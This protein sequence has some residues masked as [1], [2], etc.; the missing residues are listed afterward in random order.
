MIF[1]WFVES[2]TH[3]RWILYSHLDIFPSFSF[4]KQ[5]CYV[6]VHVFMMCSFIYWTF[7]R[8]MITLRSSYSS[9]VLY[10]KS[11][12][13]TISS[14]I[15]KVY[16]KFWKLSPWDIQNDLMFFSMIILVWLFYYDYFIMFWTFYNVSDTLT[17]WWTLNNHLVTFWLFL[18]RNIL[19]HFNSL[20]FLWLDE[21]V[22]LLNC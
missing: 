3:F 12:F 17:C 1:C 8:V 14:H 10:L 21:I 20:W 11:D 5:L 19:L 15:T 16:I 18:L 9:D 6:D 7:L 2:I 4:T 13:S 22:R